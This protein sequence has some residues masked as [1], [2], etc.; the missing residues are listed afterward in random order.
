MQ[1]IEKHLFVKISGI[2]RAGKGLFTKRF[3][4]KGSLITAYKGEITTWKKVLE[5]E[6]KTKTFN[7]Y[8]YFLNRDHVIDAMCCP[9]VLARYSNDAKGLHKVMGLLNNC[10]FTEDKDLVFVEAIKDIS[11][12]AEI[13]I[14][15]GKEYWRIVRKIKRVSSNGK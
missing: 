10:R 3:I 12:G 8:L 6:K 7:P 11:A 4:P 14:S 1:F 5:I 15:Y 9:E 13:L 2:P